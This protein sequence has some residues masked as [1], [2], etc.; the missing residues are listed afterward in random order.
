M[1]E[2]GW[3][4]TDPLFAKG[5]SS[6][7]WSQ[8]WADKAPTILLAST[9]TPTLSA[10]PR[11]L[12]SIRKL[13][14]DGPFN[15]LVTLHPMMPDQIVRAYKELQG[16]RLRFAGSTDLIPL[17]QAAD[18]MVADTTSAVHEFLLQHKPVVTLRNTRPATPDRYPGAVRTA[19][20]H[21]SAM[22][23]PPELMRA[24]VE[25][26]DEI[27]PYRDGRS[28]ERVLAATQDFIEHHKGRLKRKPLNLVRRIRVRHELGY[29]G[30]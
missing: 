25:F 11:L 27:H 21:R 23:R 22:A 12:E 14:C 3:P 24:I 8:G 16:P 26:A 7:P 20:W 30:W 4:K 5:T 10:A 13:A 29:Y 19:L 6:N 2:T 15:W 18:L 17:M 28:S 1:V 9:F